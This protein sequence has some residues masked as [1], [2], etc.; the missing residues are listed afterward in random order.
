MGILLTRNRLDVKSVES[1][2][3]VRELL[4]GSNI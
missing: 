3:F 4:V 1:D 2:R